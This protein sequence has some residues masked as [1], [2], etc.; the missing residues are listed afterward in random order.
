MKRLSWPRM[1]L[2]LDAG[3]SALKAILLDED[4]RIVAS[5]SREYPLHQPHPG[6]SEQDPMDWWD[7]AKA[8]IRQ[9]ASDSPIR[10]VGLS[11]QMH[12]CVLLD[13]AA[14]A[15]GRGTP[16]RRALLW[17][18]QR[19]GA[20]C[21]WIEERVGGRARLVELVGNAALT[22]FTLPKIL[23][24]RDHEPEL[25]RSI[26]AVLLPK[27]FIGFMLTGKVATDVGDASGVLLLD[28]DR[29]SWSAEMCH[30][31]GIDPAILPPVFES[32]A[33]VGEL[34][35]D[36]AAETGLAPGTPVVAGSG[37]NQTG[38]IGAGIVAPGMVL[39]TL[40]TSGVIYAHAERPRRDLPS[41]HALMPR[42]SVPSSYPNSDPRSSAKSPA[43][44]PPNAERRTLN[45]EPVAGR[46]HTMY[47]A[48]GTPTSPGQWCVT[49]CMLSAGGSLKWA[50]DTI[51]PGVPYES[52]IDEASR[53]PPGAE[54]LIFLPY[55]TGERCPYPDP[56]ARGGWIGLTS[57]HTRAHLIRAVLEGVDGG[58]ADAAGRGAAPARARS[59]PRRTARPRPALPA[60]RR[61]PGPRRCRRAPA[62]ATDRAGGRPRRGCRGTSPT[63]APPRPR[64]GSAPRRGRRA[65]RREAPG[66]EPGW[67]E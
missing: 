45:A 11:G 17:N 19:T 9:L 34:S 33:L 22:G 29:R 52:L 28:I 18:D 46:L 59:A 57:R 42:P 25:F 1:V 2:G 56:D 30:V 60:P 14:V 47:A 66:R 27:D 13:R 65:G 44:L 63:W 54:G 53:V 8:A 31:V 21:R 41:P 32:G 4:G 43:P 64:A 61:G 48:T 12:G 62:R 23:W 26:A 10:A 38:A 20:E 37:D 3:T 67:R 50:R 36:A 49:G 39:A 7:A 40:G 35:R 51:A 16:L 24:V 58:G 15:R 5:A 6:W 55:L